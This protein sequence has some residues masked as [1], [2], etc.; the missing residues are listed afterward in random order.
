MLIRRKEF[1]WLY[2]NSILSFSRNNIMSLC[3]IVSKKNE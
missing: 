2:I 1:I 3:V